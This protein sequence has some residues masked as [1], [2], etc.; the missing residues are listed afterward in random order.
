M[1][2]SN[3]M[4]I[5]GDKSK[6]SNDELADRLENNPS[7]YANEAVA[8]LRMIDACTAIDERQDIKNAGICRTIAEEGV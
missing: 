8:R 1:K 2:S 3:V 4:V 7:E 5:S 6:L